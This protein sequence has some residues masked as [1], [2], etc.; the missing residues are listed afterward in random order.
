MVYPP[1]DGHLSKYGP[2]MRLLRSCDEVAANHYATP[3]THHLSCLPVLHRD[4]S[5]ESGE[6]VDNEP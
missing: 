2:D 1:E 4:S 6:L 3:P 5:V